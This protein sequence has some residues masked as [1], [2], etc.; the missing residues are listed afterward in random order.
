MLILAFTII[1]DYVSAL[2]IERASTRSTKK[3][4]LVA[5]IVANVGVL[6]IFKY[7]TFLNDNLS[8]LFGF[9]NNEN[10]FPALEILL[11][12]GLSFHTFQAMSYTIEVYR[13]N[14][15]AEKHFGIYSLYVMFF[16]QLVA[17]PIER[18]SELLPQ[19]R[20]KF[21][22]DYDR[23]SQGLNRMLW[24]FF[25]KMVIADRLAIYVDSVYGS[26]ESY[27]G[28]PL[29]WA[30]IFFS[31]QIY[32]DFSGYC[33]IAIGT[34]K[35][36]GFRLR[37]NF[38]FPYLSFSIREF[39]SRWHM[40]LST[41]FRDYLYF[42]MG[43]S[44]KG[45][46]NWILAILTVFA[47]SGL[48]HGAAWTFVVWGLIHAVL[49]LT[50]QSIGFKV[51]TIW[52]LPLVFTLVTFSWIFFR[53]ESWGDA[54]HI[55]KNILP[56]GGLIGVPNISVQSFMINIGLIIFLMSDEAIRRFSSYGSANLIL[57]VPRLRRYAQ[58][59]LLASAVALAGIF[60][61]QSFIYFQF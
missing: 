54:M 48:W 39:W 11:P 43:G 45:N 56:G 16:P 9:G 20:M 19:F 51:R 24:G 14:Q 15:R 40:S 23:I 42:P 26:P 21:N 59:A 50:E 2:L 4:W 12:V 52:R 29:I 8:S 38:N 33:D 57:P 18:P 32:C 5:S 41:W 35:V 28:W 37:E 27:A 53:A 13:G 1:V 3:A 17:G 30:T 7:Y 61:K 6:A 31:I 10:L 44:Q 58:N 36:L 60:E 55:V 34:A 22:F 47:I 49:Y 46:L 25:K